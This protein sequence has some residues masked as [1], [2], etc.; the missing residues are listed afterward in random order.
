MIVAIRQTSDQLFC[1]SSDDPTYLKS[2]LA[3]LQEGQKVLV[4]GLQTLKVPG[5]KQGSPLGEWR[6]WQGGQVMVTHDLQ[7]LKINP[8]LKKQTWEHLQVF[9]GLQ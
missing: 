5:Q 2:S 4:F 1:L 6:P 8:R 7:D 9:A 3:R